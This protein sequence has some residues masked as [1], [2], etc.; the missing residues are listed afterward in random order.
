MRDLLGLA[1]AN[2][3]IQVYR[4]GEHVTSATTNN[5]GKLELFNMPEGDYRVQARF[6]GLAAS[7][8]FSLSGDSTERVRVIFS[9]YTTIIFLGVIGGAL[10]LRF[11]RKKT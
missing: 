4:N 9:L 10:A 8:S 5:R 3:Q 11:I 7:R 1:V 2:A 6:L